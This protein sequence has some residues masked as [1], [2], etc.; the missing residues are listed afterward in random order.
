M[1]CFTTESLVRVLRTLQ[2]RESEGKEPHLLLARNDPRWLGSD[3]FPCDDGGLPAI[4][5]GPDGNCRISATDGDDALHV[6]AR[7][8]FFEIHLDRL[9]ARRKP[10]EHV[11]DAT[12]LG[13]GAVLGAVIGGAIG[14]GPGAL[15][16][17]AIGGAAGAW[18]A[19]RPPRWF[20]I[21][22]DGDVVEVST[23]GRFDAARQAASFAR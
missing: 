14:K 16:G 13:A 3:V 17:A 11:A 21:A 1:D 9:D 23:D 19:R 8:G 18:V 12:L 5:P 6:K 2:A 22:A 15:V 7:D 10:V 20:M 4:D